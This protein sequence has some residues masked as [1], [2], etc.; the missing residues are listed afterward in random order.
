MTMYKAIVP[1]KPPMQVKCNKCD[2]TLTEPGGLLFSPPVALYK[3]EDV[4]QKTHLC[5]SCYDEVWEFIFHD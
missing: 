5:K 1:P 4:V 2:E 3:N